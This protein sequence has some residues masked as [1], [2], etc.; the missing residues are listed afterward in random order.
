LALTRSVKTACGGGAG[1]DKANATIGRSLLPLAERTKNDATLV[2]LIQ[3]VMGPPFADTALFDM[4]IWQA[5][6][7]Q[8]AF[9]VISITAFQAAALAMSDVHAEDL[10]QVRFPW[11]AF[12]IR[13]PDGEF[14]VMLSDDAPPM[15]SGYAS[16][17]SYLRFIA[18]TAYSGEVLAGAPEQPRL[19]PRAAGSFYVSGYVPAG[20]MDVQIHSGVR[21]PQDLW[22]NIDLEKIP[23]IS[24]TATIAPSEL[25]A[26]AI[27]MMNRLV[28]NVSMAMHAHGYSRPK[29]HKPRASVGGF[30]VPGDY[31]LGTPVTVD[32]REHLAAY[33][34]GATRS[35]HK[36]RWVVRGHWRNQPCGEGFS[37][38]KRTWIQPHYSG[39][40]HGAILVREHVL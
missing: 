21:S 38:R 35:P 29:S 3:F 31:V 17:R 36:T 37:E 14:P 23:G 9:P 12:G 2:M 4:F 28:V 5:R 1:L 22:T 11:P 19:M 15:A 8:F 30:F 24:S 40:K 27:A 39:H 25:E 10:L 32:A 13:I 33:L 16:G 26:R 20:S 18:A 34:V 7:A 6:W